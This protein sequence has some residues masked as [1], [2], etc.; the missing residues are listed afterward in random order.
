MPLPPKL[1]D[2]QRREN[3]AKATEARKVR[4]A[5]KEDL[6]T[7]RRTF[8]DL[9]GMVEDGVVAKMKVSTLLEAVPGMGKIRA[10]KMMERLE[11][12]GSRHMRG[13]GTKQ[14]ELLA[15]EFDP[16]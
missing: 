12:S 2:E 16:R 4:A 8:T 11:I 7:G 5:I 14:R 3:L 6:R 13:L 1:S 10:Q 9:L 15:K